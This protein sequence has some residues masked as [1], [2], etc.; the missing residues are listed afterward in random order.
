MANLPP[1]CLE[2]GQGCANGVLGAG[3]DATAAREAQPAAHVEHQSE[4]DEDKRAGERG[5]AGAERDD[6][7]RAGRDCCRAAGSGSAQSSVLLA[8]G[9]A[10]SGNGGE[11]RTRGGRAVVAPPPTLRGY[12]PRSRASAIGDHCE[13]CS[14]AGSSSRSSRRAIST[15]CSCT[16]IG[17][18]S[19]TPTARSRG[20]RSRTSQDFDHGGAP[21]RLLGA[22]ADIPET[23]FRPLLG[24]Q[25]R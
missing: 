22:H 7:Q 10:Q 1:L 4:R 15:T 19:P 23:V 24:E 17:V 20:A 5:R 16:S 2:R 6:R 13:G 3:A 9:E 14:C 18:W 25:A 8:A 11:A 12:F 21:V